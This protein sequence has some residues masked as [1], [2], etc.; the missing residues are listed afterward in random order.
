V[1]AGERAGYVPRS[2]LT[3]DVAAATAFR[4]ADG[5]TVVRIPLLGTDLAAVSAVTFVHLDGPTTVH[6]LV[7]AM[8]DDAHV[9]I[10]AWEDGVQTINTV[11]Q[12]PEDSGAAMS[13]GL[14]WSKLNSCL[15]NA[16]ISWAIIAVIGVACA[17]A[18]A[19]VVACGSC[20]AVAA[21]FTSGT[22]TACVTLAWT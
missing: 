1:A 18:C 4:G 2:G 5:S 9:A 17:A 8:T 16:G 15:A 12:E 13:R 20:I 11:L 22:I 10:E 21:G 6:E 14:S 19:T 7:A 3:L